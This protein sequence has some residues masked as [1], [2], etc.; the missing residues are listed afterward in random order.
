MA[1]AVLN[2]KVLTD[3]QVAGIFEKAV[4]FLGMRGVKVTHPEGLK[5]LAAGGAVIDGESSRVKFPR[6]VIEGALRTVPRSISLG[7]R[8]GRPDMMLPHPQGLFYRLGN[9]GEPEYL[10]VGSNTSRPCLRDDVVEWAQLLEVLDNIA[11]AA[12]PWPT[13]TPEKVADICGIRTLLENTSKHVMIHPYSFGSLEYLIELGKVAAD[14]SDAFKDRPNVSMIV[15]ALSPFAFKDMDI[16]AII[17]SA[18]AGVPM[19]I[20]SLPLVGANAPVTVGG[21]VLEMAIE[22]MAMLVMSQLILPGAKVIAAPFAFTLNMSTGRNLQESIEAMQIS[23]AAVQFFKQACGIPTHYEPGS[24]SHIPDGHATMEKSLSGLMVAR[25]GCDILGGAGQLDVITVSSPIQL[26]LDDQLVPMLE[27]L[28]S[29][30]KTDD[31]AV[32]WAEMLE[33]E[34]GSTYL[35][36]RHTVKHCREAVRP[37]LLSTLSRD[38]WLAEGAKD[39]QAR[40]ADKFAE[41]KK[42]MKPLELAPEVKKEFERIEQSARDHLVG[43]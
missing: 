10:D 12:T 23:S 43:K 38:V 19:H 34:P 6:D 41:L 36:L 17:L 35:S 39:L 14:T 32:A 3:E 1:D 30:V 7:A 11:L 4:S 27:R 18:R 33:L 37:G 22:I 16:E 9:T 42:Q 28:C 29:P 15:C 25:S 20:F 21:A 13:D 2:L 5:L 40:A 8:N 24:D 31:D 26:I